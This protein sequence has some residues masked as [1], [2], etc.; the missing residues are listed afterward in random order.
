MR[1]RLG[2]ACLVLL[3]ACGEDGG[4]VQLWDAPTGPILERRFTVERWDTAWVAGGG[5]ADSTLLH[6]YGIQAG[7]GG[8]YVFD[9]GAQ[10]LVSLRPDGRVRWTYGRE[11][12]GPDE[13]RNLRD[14][15]LGADGLIYLLDPRNNRVT[16][17]DSTAR[18]RRRIPLHSV[19]H[20]E[21]LAPFADG[22]ILLATM[23]QDTP[24]VLLGPDGGRSGSVEL[25]WKGFQRVHPM[26]RQ[27]LTAITPDGRS[28]VYA[29][30][31]G[32]GWFPFDG[33]RPARY[34]GRYADHRPFPDVVEEKVGGGMSV[35]F[36]EYVPCTGC[37]IVLSDSSAYVLAGG[38]E[39]SERR[40]VD[41]YRW[42]DGSYVESYRL[43]GP[44]RRMALFNGTLYLVVDEPVPAVVALRPIRTPG[45]A[46]W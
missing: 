26:A 24:F 5:D 10:R 42:A 37:D 9:V 27:G 2:A 35:R 14:M 30:M 39:R 38:S 20:A 18:V 13:F 29:F 25:P 1:P 33:P 41:R 45:A 43:P 6:P 40:V 28:W 36:K 31:L 21:Q 4:A 34:V 23:R 7:A 3:A 32:D 15:K 8:V 12:A 46:P 19:G 22:R 17:L 44:A 11:G 16:L